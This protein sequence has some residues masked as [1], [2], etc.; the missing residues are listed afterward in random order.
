MWALDLRCVAGEQLASQFSKFVN[1]AS[2]Q[3]YYQRPT[4]MIPPDTAVRSILDALQRNDYP[5]ENAGVRTAYLFSKPHEC[6]KL[7]AGQVC[8]LHARVLWRSS[9]AML[10]SLTRGE[11][12]RE[13]TDYYG[14][15]AGDA[16]QSSKLGSPRGMAAS[17]SVLRHA[18]C[19]A[20]RRHG[21][22]PTMAGNCRFWGQRLLL[23][24]RL[25]AAEAALLLQVVSQLRFPSRRM[26]NKA[27]QAVRVTS[28]GDGPRSFTF[29]FCLERVEVGP[30]KVRLWKSR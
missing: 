21:R 13:R 15:A 5:E 1:T 17:C 14:S 26:G 10:L 7:A 22:L 23:F 11:L 6:E 19:S 20:V 9:L 29:T 12:G 25:C 24:A 27:V 4:P 18:A 8:P 3:S 2:L 30:Y 16:C 28:S